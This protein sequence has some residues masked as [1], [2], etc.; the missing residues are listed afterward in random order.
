VKR[1]FLALTLAS[2]AALAGGTRGAA[3][4][5]TADAGAALATAADL[6]QQARDTGSEAERTRLVGEAL[7]ALNAEPGLAAWSWLRQPLE[8][9]P[10]DLRRA[11]ER[12][13]TAAATLQ[14]QGQS[15]RSP[16][17]D[18]G[19]ARGLLAEVL[20]DPRF[21][22]QSWLDPVPGWLL[23]AVLIVKQLLDLVWNMARWPVDRLLDL[24]G[25]LLDSP[26][27]ILLGLAAIIGI[28]ML[29][30]GAVRS[31]LVRQ[32]E[33]DLPLGPL[34]PS[35]AEA[36]IAAQREA[37]LGRYR[38]ACH[39]VLLSTLLWIEEYGDAR[40]DPS[41]TN[42]EHLRRAQAAAHPTI[43]RALGPLVAAFD[44]LWYGTGAV[45]EADYRRLLDLA[46]RV[47]ETGREA[48]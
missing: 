25:E 34:P 30:R 15:P 19:R 28:I 40:F 4:A 29:Y 44:R 17:I 31:A 7:A 2:L 18:A 13:T 46:G 12:L 14:S 38:E 42:R 3:A 9:N 41:A 6:V 23:P 16:P 11:H 47:R 26:L 43:A 36:L 39:F 24:I 10:P 22:Q 35:A 48:A 1:L 33:I 20:A 8:A 27:M 21:H 45:T 5:S 37:T 32:A